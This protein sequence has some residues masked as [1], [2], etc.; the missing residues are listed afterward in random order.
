MHA[1]ASLAINIVTPGS[2]SCSAPGPVP[3]AVRRA[4]CSNGDKLGSVCHQACI[5]GYESAG[6]RRSATRICQEKI[7]EKIGAIYF[8]AAAKWTPENVGCEGEGKLGATDTDDK[9]MQLILLA[10]K[11]GTCRASL[12]FKFL[13]KLRLAC[14]KVT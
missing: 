5:A 3:R 4:S 12:M 10:L 2:D 1:N 14:I 9:W 11:D 6:G 7:T 8:G 13:R